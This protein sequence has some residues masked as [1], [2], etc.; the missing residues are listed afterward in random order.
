MMPGIKKKIKT[1]KASGQV[2]THA[3]HQYGNQDNIANTTSNK[4]VR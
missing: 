4:D 2:D 3:L 1:T